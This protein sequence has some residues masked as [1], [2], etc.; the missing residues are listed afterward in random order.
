M[1]KLGSV[2]I[3]AILFLCL[4]LFTKFGLL[5]SQEAVLFTPITHDHFA[6]DDG[7]IYWASPL[8]DLCAGHEIA[9]GRKDTHVID[10]HTVYFGT[11]CEPSVLRLVARGGYSYYMTENG[12]FRLWMRNTIL[13]A[14]PELLTSVNFGVDDFNLDLAVDD[15]FVYWRTKVEIGKIGRDGS[16]AVVDSSYGTSALSIDAAGGSST[17]QIV[18]LTGDALGLLDLTTDTY[19]VL[20]ST[21]PETPIKAFT[22]NEGE[23]VY[24]VERSA[25]NQDRIWKKRMLPSA[26]KELVHVLD[27]GFLLLDL[28]ADSEGVYW[29]ER[30]SSP[31]A[32]VRISLKTPGMS[33]ANPGLEVDSGLSYTST[34]RLGLSETHIYYRSNN[35]TTVRYPK[36]G[37][38]PPDLQW[39]DPRLEVTQA[40]QDLDNS[41]TLV[42]G[43]RTIV[44][45]FPTLAAGDTDVI[46]EHIFAVLHG[47]EDPN[48]NGIQDPSEADLP[49]SPIT[50]TVRPTSLED[51]TSDPFSRSVVNRN[52]L[53][54]I[55][56]SWRTGT[57]TLRAEINA[58]D[59]IRDAD[60]SNN[61]A[62][63]T[64]TF[65]RI[66]P[67]CI[68]YRSVQTNSGEG[69][70]QFNNEDD[71]EEFSNIINRFES[72]YPVDRIRLGFR[73]GF[74]RKRAWIAAPFI[75]G[76]STYRIPEDQ[77][78][79][80][81]HLIH[82]E[83]LD[84]P[85]CRPHAEETVRHYIGLTP[86]GTT[87]ASGYASTYRHASWVRM[88]GQQGGPVPMVGSYPGGATMM[89]EV[90]HN[91]N[92][93]SGDRWKHVDCGSP[94]NIH[95][96]YPYPTMQIGPSLPDGTIDP[97]GLFGFD[98][99]SRTAI[100]P[101]QASSFMSYC[102]PAWISDYNWQ[103]LID[104]VGPAGSGGGGAIGGA[105]GLADDGYIL[106]EGLVEQATG[107]VSLSRVMKVPPGYLHVDSIES[108]IQRQNE[109]I[110]PHAE[111][112]I[113]SRDGAGHLTQSIRI[114]ATQHDDHHHQDQGGIASFS[115]ILTDASST[116]VEILNDHDEVLVSRVQSASAPVV[117]SISSPSG[118]V[119]DNLIVNWTSSDT[120]GDV[121]EHTLHYSSD[122]GE[123]WMLLAS[124][125]TET[126]YILD[127]PQLLPGSVDETAPGS[128]RIRVTSSDGF[129]IGTRISN[130]FI[131]RNRRPMVF[132]MGPYD[133]QEFGLRE[134]IHFD[135][136]GWDPED[137][138]DIPF[139]AFSWTFDGLVTQVGRELTLPEGVQP[140]THQVELLVRD[141]DGR[142]SAAWNFEIN[143][144]DRG[145][146]I[147]DNDGDGILND[148]DNC[149]GIPNPG[150]EDTDN[151]GLGDVC[152]NCPLN[153]NPFQGDSDEDG[154]GD[155]CD[156]SHY[157]VR[158]DSPLSGDGL[159]W[160]TAFVTLQEAL[161]QADLQLNA[162]NET[163]EI[164]VAE[165]V[166]TPYVH[167]D[168][169][170][171]RA[172]SFKVRPGIKIVGGFHGHEHHAEDRDPVGAPA[173]LSADLDLNDDPS[174]PSTSTDNAFNILHINPNE[175]SGKVELVGLRIEGATSTGVNGSAVFVSGGVYLE[176]HEC[177]FF[178][179]ESDQGS[180]IWA[181]TG[182]RI[183][184]YSTRFLNN[185]SSQPTDG[186]TILIEGSILS[187]F[188]TSFSYNENESG[189]CIHAVN[190]RVNATHCAFVHNN[191]FATSGAAVH[192][193]VGADVYIYNSFLFDNI[194]DSGIGHFDIDEDANLNVN[195]SSIQDGYVGVGNISEAPIFE[196]EDGPDGLAGTLD[197]SLRTQA[198]SPTHD[199]GNNYTSSAL[200][201]FEDASGHSRFG[202]DPSV[203]DTGV[204]GAPIVDLGPY[205]LH[206]E[207][208]HLGLE[209]AHTECGLTESMYYVVQSPNP[210]AGFS[211]GLSW[212]GENLELVEI[213]AG[214]DISASDVLS[215]IVTPQGTGEAVVALVL[216]SG[217]FI[218][219]DH[220]VRALEARFRAR[221]DANLQQI[222]E[223][224]VCIIEDIGTP[225]VK[226]VYTVPGP[227]GLPQSENPTFGCS[228][229]M[230][231][232]DLEAPTIQCPEDMVV[233]PDPETG[234]AIV[235]WE[236]IGSDACGDVTITYEPEPG[237][238][239][240][241]GTH[242][243][244]CTVED[245]AGNTDEC[246]FEITVENLKDEFRRGDANVDGRVDI[247]DPISILDHLFIG[248]PA[249]PCFGAANA[250]DDHLLD[251][252]DP[253]TLLSYLF[254]GTVTIPAPGPDHCGLDPTPDEFE[255]S[256]N[257]EIC[258]P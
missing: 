127:D 12:I 181:L 244:I 13:S 97:R 86:S 58:G 253:I 142:A 225:P 44:R 24:W 247:T 113:N 49:D 116:S 123:T 67:V 162:G 216:N 169:P 246:S 143:V 125:L 27:S 157:F 73:P 219:E 148:D 94:E 23:Y 257:Q 20:E 40:I 232:E 223:F 231:T 71:Q 117:N 140:G 145:Y 119:V 36:T 78:H 180:A 17:G 185:R 237:T 163:V 122:D 96:A 179:N 103:G 189:G 83:P 115:A 204:G 213:V 211:S 43:K 31:A 170:E 141:S 111:L 35:Q 8:S 154:L 161:D 234:T 146:P 222:E 147:P 41:V 3:K 200:N 191:T 165:G 218:D 63:S 208:S 80:L 126:F 46:T 137:G 82:D 172:A 226:V 37:I 202:E 68:E 252:T 18:L 84:R 62:E 25:S 192:L 72:M 214:P 248:G 32:D 112:Q 16:G 160:E 187:L 241:V 139:N 15:N 28:K 167:E 168:D 9:I 88:D 206:V 45:A 55:P 215:I 60:S 106:I 235:F 22:D 195:Y 164:W 166:Y 64:V 89:Q 131:V 205:E 26:T 74:L 182:S 47:F 207:P 183:T 91:Y 153:A 130:P 121:L 188:N 104:R 134:A 193:G 176:M 129:R 203:S 132:L 240:E 38:A 194:G 199:A 105:A 33:V 135:A 59:M 242:T 124:G 65:D 150:Q 29:L 95:A 19:T 228:H 100:A 114:P 79:I 50:P 149:L 155:E 239:F 197:D 186:G 144:R 7:S 51:R 108:A 173:V 6:L 243:V 1:L 57:I 128:S 87:G 175:D 2:F 5:H 196:N 151:D 102:R 209:E 77:D 39:L 93:I 177:D 30:R 98:W 227:N 34:F 198:G 159:S 21:L 81:N 56:P 61:F 69:T 133:G 70:F 85:E 99:L 190:T 256:Y 255:C 217:V 54:V 212:D 233:A 238:A 245:E 107:N 201:I 75:G 230:I 152:D 210:V 174:D 10:P 221:E 110:D 171:P 251:I 224:E 4:T 92:G 254:L 90:A 229:M 120:D 178:R 158:Q 109:I 76:G 52:F 236:A 53:F 136:R 48:G 138:N 101:N 11:D 249:S 118:G 258:E 184:T 66:T 220:P 42:D 250:N 156:I 14:E